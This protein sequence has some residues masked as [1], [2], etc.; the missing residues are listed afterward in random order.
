MSFFSS[1][2]GS[3][4]SKSRVSSEAIKEEWEHFHYSELDDKPVNE[5]KKVDEKTQKS[6]Q[7][8]RSPSAIFDAL[9]SPSTVL[10]VETLS[11]SKANKY[12]VI[13]KAAR[14]ISS[15]ICQTYLSQEGSII[16]EGEKPKDFPSREITTKVKETLATKLFNRMY[17]IDGGAETQFTLNLETPNR[18]PLKDTLN[19]YGI[20]QQGFPSGPLAKIEVTTKHVEITWSK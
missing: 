16:I 15:R 9:V 12:K 13:D 10:D 14:L 7:I 2:F 4:T 6:G 20:S 3:W 8:T 11:F 19:Q 1:L 18:N 17:R 5:G